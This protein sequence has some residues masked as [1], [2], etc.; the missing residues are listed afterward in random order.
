[1]AGSLKKGVK[2]FDYNGDPYLRRRGSTMMSE[3]RG[4]MQRRHR[5]FLPS[6]IRALIK[7][8]KSRRAGS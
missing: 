6:M 7:A 3:N 1:M 5:R 4:N 8:S 2:Q